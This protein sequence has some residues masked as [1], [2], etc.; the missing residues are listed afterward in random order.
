MALYVP[1]DFAAD[2]ALARRLIDAHPFATLLTATAPEP[3]LSHLPLVRDG[4]VL[5]GHLARANPQA[6]ALGAAPSIAIFHGPHAYVSPTWYGEPDAMVPTWNYCTV[7][8]RGQAVPVDDPAERERLMAAMVGRFEGH[9]AGAWRFA[10]AGARRE[11]MLTGVV[12]FRLPM[13]QVTAKL[14]LSQN[15]TP[16]DRERVAAA[17]ERGASADDRATAAWMRAVAPR[18]R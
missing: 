18:R 5:L 15:R 14:K 3:Q 4:D 16:D 12:A 1:P 11:A 17:L 9:G 13:A 8:V 10:L 2:D 7:H 6:Q